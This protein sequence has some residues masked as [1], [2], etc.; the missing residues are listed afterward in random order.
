MQVH[1]S[2]IADGIEK[3]PR[4]LHIHAAAALPGKA[5]IIHKVRAAAQVH[6]TQRQRLIH[7]QQAAAIAH[8]PALVAQGFLDGGAQGNAHILNG[9]VAV[10]LQIAAALHGQIKQ[11]VTGKPVQHVVKKADAGVQVGLACA[12]QV[13]GQG[14][15]SLP[16]VAGHS[17]GACHSVTSLL[18]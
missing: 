4:H 11:A 10:D 14:D 18:N 8:Q 17:C 12:V 15:L 1:H 16:R 2:C 7:G 5:G 13:D 3:L 9:V 6:S